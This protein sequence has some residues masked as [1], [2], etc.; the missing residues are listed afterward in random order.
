MS[1]NSIVM[2]Y[3]ENCKVEGEIMTKFKIAKMFFFDKE[4]QKEIA[5]YLS[6]HG[7]TINKIIRSCKSKGSSSEV[8]EYLRHGKRINKDKLL[9]VFDFF[10]HESRKPLGNKRSISFGS[11]EELLI[12]QKF[13]DD[14]Y[15]VKRMFDHL[16][17]EGRDMEKLSIGKIKGLYR[18]Y[19]LKAKKVRTVNGERRSLYNYDLLGV[20]EE[21][22][23]DVKVLADKHALPKDIYDKFKYSK[24]YPKYQW[25]I[26][27]AKT[28]TR[29]LAYSFELN[30]FFGFKFLEYT[31]HWIRSHGV[32]SKINIQVDMGGEFYSGSKR[33]Q[34]T[35]NS[36][37]SKLNAYVYD[38]EGAKWK[39]NLVERSHRTDDEEFLCP[40]GSFMNSCSDFMLEAQFWIIY[41]N[42]R[43]HTRIGMKGLSPKKK[44]EECGIFNANRIINFPCLILDEFFKPLLDFF[45]EVENLFFKK[46]QNV[47]TNYQNAMNTF[48][49]FKKFIMLKIQ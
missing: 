18:K 12:L 7:N 27:D 17:R 22:Q 40:R 6:C 13:N 31:I 4:K 49:D 8:W 5:E 48:R 3:K 9:E 20:F 16:K 37:L 45:E 44:L 1:L 29:F 28:R 36:K 35:W 34:R 30:S 42:T 46:S 10:K 23:Y 32:Q 33:K 14:K 21:L 38:T 25:T 41:F 39:Q 47:L 26:I 24:R 11:K 15:G 2:S 19:G 43:S